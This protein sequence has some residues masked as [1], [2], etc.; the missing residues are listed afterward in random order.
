MIYSYNICVPSQN[1][2]KSVEKMFIGL[3]FFRK[4]FADIKKARIFASV[5]E[6][7]TNNNKNCSMV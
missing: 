2:H 5:I 3:I 6:R 1:Q 7:D 4:K